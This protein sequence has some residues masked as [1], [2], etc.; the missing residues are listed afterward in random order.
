MPPSIKP[1]DIFVLSGARKEKFPLSL[2][3]IIG[4]D[5][6]GVVKGIGDEVYGQALATQGNSGSF[7]E[8]LAVKGEKLALKPK[9]ANFEEAAAL[10]LVGSSAIQA[11][12]DHINLKSG[13]KILIHGGAGG[14]GHVAV[15]LAKALGAYVATTVKTEDVE[16]ARELGADQVIDYKTQ[17]FEEILR[18]FDVVYDLAGGETTNKSFPVLKKGGILVSMLGQPNHELAEKYGVTAL[19]QGTK[20]TSEILTRLAKFVDDGKI[21][22]HLDKVFTLDQ[23]KDAFILQASHPRGKVVLKIKG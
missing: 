19:G 14:I 3:T 20:V 21:K 11:L 15:Q 5:F 23:V 6:A 9:R 22:V 2:P 16:F 18:D 1:F 8:F 10:P 17:K 4:G 7:A 13:Q 12:E